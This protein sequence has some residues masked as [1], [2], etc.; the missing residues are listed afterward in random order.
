MFGIGGQREKAFLSLPGEACSL[1]PMDAWQP[2]IEFLDGQ[3]KA[4]ISRWDG[5]VD[6]YDGLH[7]VD[8]AVGLYKSGQFN[9]GGNKPTCKQHGNWIEP[10]GSGRTLEIG[11]RKNGKLLRIYEKGKQLGDPKSLW[12]RWELQATQQRQRNTLGRADKSW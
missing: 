2:L 4:K 1:I 11:K 7:D 9:A 8:W 6:D 3:Y 12:V 5:A 10:D